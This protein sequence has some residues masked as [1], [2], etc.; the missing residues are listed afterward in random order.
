MKFRGT[1]GDQE[2]SPWRKESHFQIF[3][4]YRKILENKRCRGRLGTACEKF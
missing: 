4:H 2:I 3:N 1:N